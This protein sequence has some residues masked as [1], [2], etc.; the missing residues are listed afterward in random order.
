MLRRRNALV[1]PNARSTP[2]TAEHLRSSSNLVGVSD[3]GSLTPMAVSYANDRSRKGRRSKD[4][5]LR[6]PFLRVLLPQARRT[7][8]VGEK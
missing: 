3:A 1:G 2:G 5:L 7:L 6:Q 8:D 4:R